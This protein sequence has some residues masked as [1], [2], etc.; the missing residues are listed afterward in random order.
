MQSVEGRVIHPL[1]GKTPLKAGRHTP[2][3]KTG[4]CQESL[5]IDKTIESKVSPTTS[6]KLRTAVRVRQKKRSYTIH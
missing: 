3:L 1:L 4:V 5:Q 6:Q 2:L